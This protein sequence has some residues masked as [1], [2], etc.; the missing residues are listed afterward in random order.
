MKL[1]LVGDDSCRRKENLERVTMHR[2]WFRK[3]S[4]QTSPDL[5]IHKFDEGSEHEKHQN[6]PAPTLTATESV[7]TR[8]FPPSHQSI[9]TIEV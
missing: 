9:K 8:R 6:A 2:Q 7:M 5:T 1:S 4:H 3:R